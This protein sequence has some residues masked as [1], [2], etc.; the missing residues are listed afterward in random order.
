M[1]FVITDGTDD[2][3]NEVECNDSVHSIR[4]KEFL[5]QNKE[6]QRPKCAISPINI[7]YNET[8]DSSSSVSQTN[9]TTSSYN[10]SSSPAQ[11]SIQQINRQ[12]FLIPSFQCVFQS[13]SIH[14]LPSYGNQPVPIQSTPNK[15]KPANS[16]VN[17]HSIHELAKSSSISANSS[18][19]TSQIQV[20]NTSQIQTT[21]ASYHESNM[22]NFSIGDY[23]A[24]SLYPTDFSTSSINLSNSIYN[25]NK[26]N[27]NYF[28]NQLDIIPS[29]QNFYNLYLTLKS[30]L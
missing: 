17:F 30:N 13:P 8:S 18:S 22:N 14:L 11:L 26:E 20:T 4:I 23:S 10:V 3:F 6:L 1:A 27:N 29:V 16:R 5:M 2:E 25:S 7:E 21:Q 12:N 28:H 9:S 15:S 19:S 24:I